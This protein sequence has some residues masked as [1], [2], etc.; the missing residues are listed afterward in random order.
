LNGTA[1][2]RNLP[3]KGGRRCPQKSQNRGA[4]AENF[5]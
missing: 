1:H 5:P 2:V 3:H 4:H